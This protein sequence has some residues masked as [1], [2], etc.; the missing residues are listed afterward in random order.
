M[1]ADRVALVIVALVVAALAA[2]F[3]WRGQAAQVGAGPTAY[4]QLTQAPPEV[5]VP[6]AAFVGDSYSAGTGSSGFDNRFTTLVA[7]YEGWQGSSFAYGG[8]GYLRAATQNARIGCGQ[9]ACPNYLDVVDR[10]I[11]ANPNIVVVSGGR[12]DVELPEAQVEQAIDDFYARLRAGLPEAQIIVVSPVWAYS[13]P[14]AQ[15]GRIR[16]AVREAAARVGAMYLDIG[17]PLVD[18]RTLLT[19]DRVHPNDAGHA[20]LARLIEVALSAAEQGATDPASP[21]PS[22]TA[23]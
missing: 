10:V 3:V 1:R 4:P 15:L 9:D 16:T 20:E 11:A 22:P 8:T 18:D 13:S 19:N 14:P 6:S 5:A 7:A 21:S 17:E 12:N 2:F 23:P